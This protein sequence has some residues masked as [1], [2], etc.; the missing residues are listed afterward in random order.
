MWLYPEQLH[1]PERHQVTLRCNG[2]RRL[3]V[4]CDVT[5]L[6]GNAGAGNIVDGHRK[7]RLLRI[8]LTGGFIE[9]D[10]SSFVVTESARK[11]GARRAVPAK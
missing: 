11:S 3:L 6:K 2:P 1:S 10:A 9:V 7:G 8:V 4:S 5:E